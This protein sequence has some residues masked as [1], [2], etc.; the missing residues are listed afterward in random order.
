MRQLTV[1]E[2]ADGTATIEILPNGTFGFC[3][4]FDSWDD[5]IEALPNIEEV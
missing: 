2:S 3:Y 5:A 4:E 1:F